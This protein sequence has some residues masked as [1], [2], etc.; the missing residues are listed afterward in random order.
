MAIKAVFFDCGNVLVTYKTQEFFSVLR[1]I[2]GNGRDPSGYFGKFD[3]GLFVEF[4]LGQV[5][6]YDFYLR[7]KE[8]FEIDSDY[9]FNAFSTLFLNIVEPDH[10]VIDIKDA[11]KRK[12]LKLALITNN[13]Q[14][15]MRL[16][17]REHPEVL[18][19]FDYMMVSSR[20]HLR[21]PN[22]EMWRK[23]MKSL[24]LKA[25]ECLFIED[26]EENLKAFRKLGG[27]AYRY[28]PTE[29]HRFV[30]RYKLL[31]EREYLRQT[32]IKLGL[33]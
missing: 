30:N 14:P 31:K 3:R 6:F 18:S 15:H 32:L 26:R 12:G 19:N 33:L 21:K 20:E 29:D 23:P 22:L 17:T 9:G 25:E 24:G 16:F 11:L 1:R 13:N 8:D 4:E 10:S 7:V 27:L 5:G 2:S 28:D